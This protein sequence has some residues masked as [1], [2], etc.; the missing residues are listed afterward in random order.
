MIT[1]L[2]VNEIKKY[3]T[4]SVDKTK[5]LIYTMC[6]VKERR[7]KNKNGKRKIKKF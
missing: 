3:F 1:S 6:E 2:L 5:N 7:H 4:K